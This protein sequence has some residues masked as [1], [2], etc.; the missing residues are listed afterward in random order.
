MKSYIPRAV[1]QALIAE[2]DATPEVY[3][4]MMVH[5]A[6]GA[7]PTTFKPGILRVELRDE[8]PLPR[9]DEIR[10]RCEVTLGRYA[11]FV[12]IACGTVAQMMDLDHPLRLRGGSVLVPAR[13]T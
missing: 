7:E 3:R 6:E 8:T 12:P 13:S 11:P 2:L 10:Q 1:H 5:H 4:A 9:V